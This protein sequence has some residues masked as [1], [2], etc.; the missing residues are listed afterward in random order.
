[1]ATKNF[2]DWRTE[3]AKYVKFASTYNADVDAEVKEIVRDFC[4]D[5][6]IWKI[7]LDRIT[8]VADT[9]TYT[10]T[11]PTTNGKSETVYVDNVKYKENGAEDT[12]FRTLE[13]FTREERDN[14]ENGAWSFHTGSEPYKFYSNVDR[15]LILY[16][17]PE[18]GSTL[19]LLV[20]VTVK[21]TDDATKCPDFI[22]IDYK[23]DIAI[24]A[25]KNLMLMPNKP[26]S[27]HEQGITYEK[28]YEARRDECYQAVKMGFSKAAQQVFIP[29][30][31]GSRSQSWN[32]R[33]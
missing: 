20:R 21:P 4:R 28:R 13:P 30:G 32:W 11:I 8:T 19:G 18:N 9:E 5:T 14:H 1:M 24:G 7:T 6:G 12:Q 10:L 25:A 33:P 26:W 15:Q 27:D 29:W 17:I 16:P 2:S 3:V 23:Q 31:G 22:Y